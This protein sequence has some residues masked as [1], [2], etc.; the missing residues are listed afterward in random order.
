MDMDTAAEP[1]DL[2]RAAKANREVDQRINLAV[3]TLAR[4]VVLLAVATAVSAAV[5]RWQKRQLKS[6][7]KLQSKGQREHARGRGARA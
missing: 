7:R 2:A 4:K 3:A 6:D 1:A 5:G